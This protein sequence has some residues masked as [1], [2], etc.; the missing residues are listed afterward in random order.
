MLKQCDDLA[1]TVFTTIFAEFSGINYHWYVVTFVPISMDEYNE[2]SCQ[3]LM[4][5]VPYVR[6][7]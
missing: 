2:K 6:V 1:N 3:F 7:C 4:A 5:E